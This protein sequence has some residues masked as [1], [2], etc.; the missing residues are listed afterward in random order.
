MPELGLP[1][2]DDAT[3]DDVLKELCMGRRS[4]VELRQAPWLQ[5]VQS[6]IEPS[7]RQMVE[8]EAPEKLQLPN[9]H[10]AQLVYEQGRPPVLPVRIQ[11]AFGWKQ[12][13]R[14]AAGRIPVLLHLLAPNMRPQQVTDDLASFWAG[15]TPTS[16]RN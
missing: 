8:R 13:P 7:L 5:T 9:G 14:I 16:E 10:R 12:T 3:I 1:K 2:F 15:A 6:R 11:D 4:F